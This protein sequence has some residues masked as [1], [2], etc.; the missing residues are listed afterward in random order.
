MTKVSENIITRRSIRSFKEKLIELKDLNTI[1]TAGLYAPSA[2]NSQKNQFTVVQGTE[3][4][5]KLRSTIALVLERPTYSRFYGAPTLIIT[6]A[7]RDYKFGREDTST[8][9]ENIFLQA[10]DLGIGS[11][12]INQLINISDKPEVREVLRE[13]QIPDNHIVYGSAAI[14]YAETTDSA[15][16]EIKGTIVFA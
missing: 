3:K 14:G 8:A 5:E 2:M 7:P 4:L 10:H 6:S 11:V 1:L 16:K 12:W 9:L 15:A 13:L